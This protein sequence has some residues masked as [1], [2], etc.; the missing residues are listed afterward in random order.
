M[1]TDLNSAA[2]AAI[3]IG[4]LIIILHFTICLFDNK[5]TRI[6]SSLN[7]LLHLGFFVAA[8]F[9]GFDFELV[10]CY[11]MASVLIYSLLSYISYKRKMAGGKEVTERD[12]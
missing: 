8:F 9:G 3:L 7:I 4:T 2:I 5:I 1:P 6:I 12:I 10:V 11:F